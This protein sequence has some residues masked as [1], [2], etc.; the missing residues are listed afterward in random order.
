MV[1]VCIIYRGRSFLEGSASH[2]F[3]GVNSKKRTISFGSHAGQSLSVRV[4][5]G[6][7]WPSKRSRGSLSAAVTVRTVR[8]AKA[9]RLRGVLCSLL[10]LGRLRRSLR[11]LRAFPVCCPFL[12]QAPAHTKSARAP[13]CSCPSFA[14]DDR[15]LD[16]CPAHLGHNRRASVARVRLSLPALGDALEGGVHRRS[17]APLPRFRQAPRKGGAACIASLWKTLTRSV[18]SNAP[19]RQTPLRTARAGHCNCLL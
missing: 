16:D 11:L 9:A 1:L 5:Q 17:L 18:Y 19:H 6:W 12:S 4:Y 15:P 14:S 10:L 7:F 8:K 3:R 13:V 2:P